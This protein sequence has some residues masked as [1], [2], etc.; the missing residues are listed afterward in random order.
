MENTQNK[1]NI[2]QAD[3]DQLI[4]SL[5]NTPTTKKTIDYKH[6]LRQHTGETCNCIIRAN[7]ITGIITRCNQILQPGRLCSG[8]HTEYIQYNSLGEEE[9]RESKTN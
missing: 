1:T 9:Y 8:N 7:P 2:T 6:P 4:K 5:T 3:F